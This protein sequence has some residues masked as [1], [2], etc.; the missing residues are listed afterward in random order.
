MLTLSLL[1]CSPIKTNY[2]CLQLINLTLLFCSQVP[3]PVTEARPK[4]QMEKPSVTEGTMVPGEGSQGGTNDIPF[5]ASGPGPNKPGGSKSPKPTHGGS[6]TNPTH[7]Q[8]GG[9]GGWK[10]LLTYTIS[11]KPVHDTMEYL[12][13]YYPVGQ[14]GQSIQ[15]IDCTIQRCYSKKCQ[16][17][18]DD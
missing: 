12:V 18:I 4:P 17:L 8:D 16:T 7:R 9:V 14:S 3:K 6:P 13:T 5:T 2:C 1:L 11:W 10:P 15:V